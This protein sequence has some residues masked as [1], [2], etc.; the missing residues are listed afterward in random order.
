MM[1]TQLQSFI[2]NVLKFCLCITLVIAPMS[3]AQESWQET[4]FG[5]DDNVVTVDPV[6]GVE[7]DGLKVGLGENYVCASTWG[8]RWGS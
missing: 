2:N 3:Q 7:A 5:V 8:N 1:K 4:G 6:K